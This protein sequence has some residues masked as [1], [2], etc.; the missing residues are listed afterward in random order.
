MQEKDIKAQVRKQLKTNFPNWHRLTKKEKRENA[1]KAGRRSAGDHP[2]PGAGDGLPASQPRE[3]RRAQRLA[4]EHA[5][6]R[7]PGLL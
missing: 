6:H 7:P 1:Q 3:D 5:I 2:G 4:D